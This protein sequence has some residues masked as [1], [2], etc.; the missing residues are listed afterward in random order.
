MNNIYL[1]Y[2]ESFI[3]ILSGSEPGEFLRVH[4][5]Y[6]FNNLTENALQNNM[7]RWAKLCLSTRKQIQNSVVKTITIL[8]LQF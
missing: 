1:L 4:N 5:I 3:I 7:K 2:F 6:E 8:E